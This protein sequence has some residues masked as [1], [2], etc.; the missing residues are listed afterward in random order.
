MP[1]T[2]ASAVVPS[3]PQPHSYLWTFTARSPRPR[4]PVFSHIYENEPQRLR[5]EIHRLN[6][7][8]MYHFFSPCTV[9]KCGSVY[10]VASPRRW[11]TSFGKEGN[12]A[13]ESHS[14]FRHPLRPD[15]SRWPPS[16]QFLSLPQP[17]RQ[18]APAVHPHFIIFLV[19]EKCTSEA[20]SLSK[21][22]T[23]NK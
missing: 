9:L 15:T 18:P 6:P 16:P 21:G 11:L 1:L 23:Q 8:P 2:S 3:D 20:V 13:P 12:L 17:Q 5:L 10:R 19:D 7:V 14:P 22:G 4:I